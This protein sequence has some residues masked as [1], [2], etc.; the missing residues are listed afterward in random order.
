M[1]CCDKISFFKTRLT[2]FISHQ[3]T[4]ARSYVSRRYVVCYKRLV[5]QLASQGAGSNISLLD[6]I[7]S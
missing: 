6:R 4:H 5:S 1:G 3:L 2:K 7:N